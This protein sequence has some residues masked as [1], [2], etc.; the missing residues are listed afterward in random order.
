MESGG[1][2]KL[3]P[4]D[5]PHSYGIIAPSPVFDIMEKG[6][7]PPSRYKIVEC[8]SRF[9][10]HTAPEVTF[11][12]VILDQVVIRSGESC[13]AGDAKDA[14]SRWFVVVAC[15]AYLWVY[16]VEDFACEGAEEGHLV[17]LGVVAS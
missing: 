15:G 4:V 13:Y 2:T 17:A 7:C 3:L 6:L 14:A 1:R 8:S 11:E 12:G 5:L 16:E 9:D 10:F